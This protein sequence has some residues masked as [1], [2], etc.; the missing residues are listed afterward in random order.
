MYKLQF[1]VLRRLSEKERKNDD[2]VSFQPYQAC[3]A[4]NSR[5][6]AATTVRGANRLLRAGIA[7][8]SPESRSKAIGGL[9][10]RVFSLSL[11]FLFAG[12][13]SMDPRVADESFR[14]GGEYGRMHARIYA[15]GRPL[16]R[17]TSHM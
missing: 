1:G 5:T 15:L 16:A 8:K 4:F 17:I 2:P 12:G 13:E 6:R 9:V 14:S 7:D 11:S 10:N 3:R